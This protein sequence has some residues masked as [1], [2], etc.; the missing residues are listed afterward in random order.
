MSLFFVFTAVVETTHAH[1]D[2]C[3]APCPAVCLGAP[4]GTQCETADARCAAPEEQERPSRAVYLAGFVPAVFED[5][6]FHPPL[7]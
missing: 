7:I 3:D 1:E 5:E 4:C 6:I 2:S